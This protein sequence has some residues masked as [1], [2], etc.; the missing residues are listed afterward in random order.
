MGPAECPD[1]VIT[2]TPISGRRREELAELKGDVLS[3]LLIETRAAA[4]IANSPR[5][6]FSL[7]PIWQVMLNSPNALYKMG[8]YSGCISIIFF[9]LIGFW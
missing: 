5:Q 8:L 7:P 1:H 3:I 2:S 9:L 6:N 4:S